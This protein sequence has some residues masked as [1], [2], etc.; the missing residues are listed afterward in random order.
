MEPGRAMDEAV[1]IVANDHDQNNHKSSLA[2]RSY[3]VGKYYETDLWRFDSTGLRMSE[4]IPDGMRATSVCLRARVFFDLH[5]QSRS[6]SKPNSIRAVNDV[7][8]AE[9][10]SEEIA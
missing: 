3:Q 10:P 2:D 4:T 6:N 9:Q 1:E 5:L 8:L 7:S